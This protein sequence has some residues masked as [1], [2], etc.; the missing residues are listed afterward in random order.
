[1][2]DEER[3]ARENIMVDVFCAAEGIEIRCLGVLGEEHRG[4]GLSEESQ[5]WSEVLIIYTVG[6]GSLLVDGQNAENGGLTSS[7]ARR[8]VGCSRWT[9]AS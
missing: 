9:I 5:S 8:S 1:M 4:G 7:Q 2:V 3:S 6:S